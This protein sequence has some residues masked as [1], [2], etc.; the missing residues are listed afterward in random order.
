MPYCYY[1]YQR[2]KEKSLQNAGESISTVVGGIIGVANYPEVLVTTY[3]GRVFGLTTSPPGMLEAGQSDVG[4]ARLKMEIEQ[5]QE[6]LNEEKEMSNCVP[7]P[8]AVSILAV[9]HK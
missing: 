7:D 9:N 3:S 4:M 8:L 1:C 5:L 2:F 6:K